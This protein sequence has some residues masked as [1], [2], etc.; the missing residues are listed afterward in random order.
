MPSQKT[1]TFTKGTSGT[2]YTMPAD[3]WLYVKATGSASVD[4][5]KWLYIGNQTSG[6]SMQEATNF[7]IPQ[8]SIMP[9]RRNDV[10]V[11]T[12]GDLTLNTVKLY[13]LQGGN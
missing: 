2:K 1:Y 13:Y 7:D 9:V 8:E 6:I 10:V 12:W 3:G 11:M 5:G 4:K